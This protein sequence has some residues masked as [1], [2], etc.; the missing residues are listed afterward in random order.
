MEKENDTQKKPDNSEN[1]FVEIPKEGVRLVEEAVEIVEEQPPIKQ[2]RNFWHGLGPGI[3][4]GAADDDP[5]GVATYSQTGAKYGFQLLWLAGWTFPMMGAIQEMCAR[6]GLVTGRGLASNIKRHF[7]KYVLYIVA[8]LLLIANSFNI[9]ADLG[10]LANATQ[11]IWPSLNYLLLVVLFTALS[12][13]MQIFISY[14]QYAKYLK[15]LALTLM[16]YVITAFVIP[17]FDW[18]EL[19]THAFS[20]SIK[21]TKDQIILICGIL[22]T[23]ISPYLFFWQTSQEVEEQ[24][25]EGDTTIESRRADVDK[26]TIRKMRIDSWTGM[27]WSNLVMFF[28]IAVCAGTLF[29]NG[30]FEIGTAAQAASALRPL[31]GDKAYI[32]F[33]IGI[34]GTGLL[35]IPVLAGSASYAISESLG[36][37]EGLY[38]KFK[39]AAAFYGVII[40][41]MLIG[42]G[43]NF[44]GMDPIKALLY[45]A[46]VNGLVAPLI[47]V[48]II[49]ISS[50]KAIMGQWANSKFVSILGWIV[51]V[52]MILVGIAT[53]WSIFS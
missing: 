12:L 25:Q 43:I 30:T 2:I 37:K 10:A 51:T 52:F 14:S 53:I 13:V 1:L 32:L 44:I 8:V 9:G 29:K 47:L 41:A 39:Q 48:L 16:V 17:N 34:F 28:I 7:P 21:F 49:L 50:K 38:R 23:T 4:T 3:T 46:V 45:S 19:L 36:W 26:K 18:R 42:M 40:L 6:I 5:S 35:G 22:G 27:F 31:A 33:A 11:L 24:I 15:Y 20:P